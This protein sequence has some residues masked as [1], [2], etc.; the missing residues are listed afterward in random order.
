MDALILAVGSEIVSGQFVNT[1]AAWLAAAL[2]ERGVWTRRHVAVPDRMEDITGALAAARERLV[3]CTGGIGPTRDDLTRDAVAAFLGRPLLRDAAFLSHV[4]SL[5]ARRAH[6]MPANNERQADIPAG[7]EIL[8]NHRGTAAGFLADDGKKLI[9]ALPG[10]PHE[11]QAMFSGGLLPALERRSLLSGRIVTGYLRCFGASES[12]M[13]EMIADLEGEREDESVGILA[14]TGVISVKIACRGEDEAQAQARA[15][16]IKQE[17]RRRLGNLVF[18]E[19]D[20]TLPAALGRALLEG[21]HRL[22]LAESCTG[23][24]VARLVTSVAGASRWFVGGVVAYA[25]EAKSD[26]LDVPAALIARHGAV[27]AEVAQA[28]ARGAA[29]RFHATISA[30]T[31]GVA[32]PDGGT[33]D[34]P[35]GCCFIAVHDARRDATSARRVL[36]TG[37]RA[38]NQDL[39]A[40]STLNLIRLSVV[41]DQAAKGS[42]VGGLGSLAGGLGT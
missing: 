15:L 33:D 27:S 19:D 28:M 41:G 6:P 40:K 14:S 26:L 39:F 21:G 25:N 8:W 30:A 23:G 10:V 13:D 35:V 36:F 12:R 5:F 22:A 17:A 38:W 31:T 16:A 37:D 42:E 9:A 4:R 18:G 32:G 11:M 3:I 34:K 20:D 24:L 7:A 2:A 1:N 29:A